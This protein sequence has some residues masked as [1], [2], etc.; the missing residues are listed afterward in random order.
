MPAVAGGGQPPYDENMEERVAKLEEFAIETGARLVRIESRLDAMATKAD[1]AELR[2]EMHKGFAEVQ[3]GFADGHKSISDVIKW[4]IGIAIT[5]SAAGVTVMTFVLNYGVPR[6]PTTAP[7]SVP[8]PI[9]IQL[10]AQST[11]PQP[12]SPA[13]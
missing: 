5:M 7:I 11:S 4:M 8:Q 2:T 10:P 9:I 1:L 3:K 12:S 13:R 6:V